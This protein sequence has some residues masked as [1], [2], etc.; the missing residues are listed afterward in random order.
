MKQI[1]Q[2]NHIRHLL[3]LILGLF[4]L[5]IR[6]G[7]ILK[8]TYAANEIDSTIKNYYQDK[9]R[10]K[11]TIKSSIQEGRQDYEKV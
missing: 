6:L 1:D 5:A 9:L 4:V 3:Y 2:K 11:N 8:S 10:N 7:S